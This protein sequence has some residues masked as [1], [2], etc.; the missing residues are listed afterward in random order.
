MAATSC[1][2]FD[3]PTAGNVSSRT[4]RKMALPKSSPSEPCVDL[5]TR[6]TSGNRCLVLSCCQA[7]AAVLRNCAID[8]GTTVNALPR[9]EDEEKIRKP[10]QHHEPF[11]LWTFHHSLLG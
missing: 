10:L 9:I 7:L 1:G 3:V 8:N 11:T 5:P 6:S 4:E 2:L